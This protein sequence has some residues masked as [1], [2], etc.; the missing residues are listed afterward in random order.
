MPWAKLG[1]LIRFRFVYCLPEFTIYNDSLDRK[2]GDT[3]NMD[4][5]VEK[6]PTWDLPRCGIFDR[7]SNG[8]SI[9]LQPAWVSGS[10]P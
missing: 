7:W 6:Y 5:K 4:K 2:I 9:S 8:H 3:E 1:L 10:Y